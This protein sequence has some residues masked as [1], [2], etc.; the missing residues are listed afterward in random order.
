MGISLYEL[1]TG[2][3][4]AAAIWKQ[5]NDTYFKYHKTSTH[6]YA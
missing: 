1:T 6:C 5:W 4:V 2:T 3:V